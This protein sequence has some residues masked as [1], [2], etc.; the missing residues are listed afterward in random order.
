MQ[1]TK[2]KKINQQ[3]SIMLY[4]QL[5]AQLSR[6]LGP[7]TQATTQTQRIKYQ[8]NCNRICA[9]YSKLISKIKCHVA[10]AATTTLQYSQ[11][12]RSIKELTVYIR[13]KVFKNLIEKEVSC[14]TNSCKYNSAFLRSQSLSKSL[15]PPNMKHVSE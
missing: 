9:E 12:G 13:C 7:N 10:R 2:K 4:N 15:T 14:C 8:P 11:D 6:V 3:N 1:N 5:K